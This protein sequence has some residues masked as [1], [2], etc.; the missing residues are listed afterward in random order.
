MP[1]LITDINL[2]L[3]DRFLYVSC[4]GTGEFLQ[5]DVSDP[6][7][8]KKTGS[9]HLGGI[10]RHAAHPRAPK[11]RAERRSADGGAEPRWQ[12]HLLHQLALLAMGRAVLSG[13]HSKLDGKAG[14]QAGRRDGA[15]SEVLSSSS[16][17]CAAIRCAWK[18]ATPRPILTAIHDSGALAWAWGWPAL[19]L[20]GAYHGINPGMGWL[21]AVARGMQEHATKAVARAL[22]PIT[23]GH[24]L[25]IGLVVALAGLIQIV[26]PLGYVQI[27]VACALICARHLSNF[28]AP[29]FRLG[30][31]AS[32]ISRSHVLVLPDG[33]RAWRRTD[34]A[35]H[36]AARP[37][38]ANAMPSTEHHMPMA[39]G[40][41]PWAG[42]A[43]TL[44]HTLGYLSVTAL[45]AL[46]VYRKFGLGALAQSLVQ[47]RS[48]VGRRPDRHRLRRS[49]RLTLTAV[50]AA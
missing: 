41:G 5:Y 43:A 45:V 21:F 23:L 20:L 17:I 18:A 47:S 42:I 10:V 40:R 2:S 39:G 30:R 22:V 44:I 11:T 32:G 25:S 49:D 12:A 38:S 34:G 29:A 37:R 8:P 36:R 50:R 6:F 19:F 14:R 27:V 16:G 13:G 33:Q 28:A 48:G 15:G 46:L 7:H 1:P 35:A 31:N 24:A 3:D 26:L 4:W 9:I